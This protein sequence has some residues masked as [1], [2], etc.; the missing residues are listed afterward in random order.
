M[1]VNP[2]QVVGSS[3]SVGRGRGRGG[4]VPVL[5]SGAFDFVYFV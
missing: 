3:V 5:P 1:E 4:G 2:V